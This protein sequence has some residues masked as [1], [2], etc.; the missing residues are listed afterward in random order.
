MASDETI[1]IMEEIKGEDNKY[2]LI[3]EYIIENNYSLLFKNEVFEVYY[4]D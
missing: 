1:K 4:V 3:Q 2:F